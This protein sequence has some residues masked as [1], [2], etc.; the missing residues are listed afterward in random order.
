[1]NIIKKTLYKIVPKILK[2]IIKL[3]INPFNYH[4]TNWLS[5]YTEVIDN[6]VPANIKLTPNNKVCIVK[7]IMM[8]HSYYEA[9]CIEL[10]IEYET[11]DVSSND[12]IDHISDNKYEIFFVRPFVLSSYGKKYYDEISNIIANKLKLN[13]YPRIDD[14]WIYESKTRCAYEMIVNNIPHPKTHI[15]IDQNKALEY[16]KSAAYPLIF[17]TDIGSDASG[18]KLVSNFKEATKIINKCFNKGFTNFFFDTNDKQLGYVVFQDFI[19]NVREIRVIR[20]GNS[21]FVYEKGKKGNF[22][23]GSKIVHYIS[24]SI[25]LLEFVR[26]STDKIGTECMSVDVFENEN[27]EYF[28]NELQTYYGANE[29]GGI[30]FENGNQVYLDSGQTHEMRINGKNGRYYFDNGEW[31]FEEGDFARNAGCNLRVIHAFQKLGINLVG[32]KA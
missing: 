30:Y 6:A 31:I 25:E 32:Y 12:W 27:G 26:K 11:L 24:P 21:Y 4:Y 13:I 3:Y 10:G 2:N 28:V 7:D 14:L 15:F 9:A 5:K 20:I 8:R 16:A 17:K 1:M 22:H 29:P 23:S 19:K 18:V